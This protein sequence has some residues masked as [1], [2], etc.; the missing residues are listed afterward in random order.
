[1]R[2]PSFNILAI[3]IAILVT[4]CDSM[5][6]NVSP[7]QVDPQLVVYSFLSPEEENIVVEVRRSMPIF[8]GSRSGDDTVTN[9]TVKIIQGNTERTIPY[10][11]RGQYIIPQ[12]TFPLVAGQTYR[13]EVS[14]PQGEAVSG[15]TTIP[16]SIVTLD[17]VNLSEQ[18]GPFGFT[19]DLLQMKWND[20]PAE[21]NFYQVYTSEVNSVNDTF[22]NPFGN[23]GDIDNQVLSDELARAGLMTL[24]V[25]TSLGLE[26]GDTTELNVVLANTDEAY[27]RYHA[28]RLNYSGSNP[29]SEPTVMFNNVTGGVGVV[30]SYR[31]STRKMIFVR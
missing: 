23:F 4:A 25:Q 27:Y 5:V 14:T 2:N 16:L 15:T 13:I 3:L 7:P 26:A 6:T 30:A 20:N 1:M 24:T 18:R 17:S 22:I 21:R 31:K 10:F 28:L 8:S 11:R 29:F 19:I 9:A 12:T